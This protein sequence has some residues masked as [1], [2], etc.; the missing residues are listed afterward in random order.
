LRERSQQH[1]KRLAAAIGEDGRQEL[2][3]LL[4]GVIDAVGP[5]SETEED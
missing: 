1:E 5:G 4:H 3:K 2:L